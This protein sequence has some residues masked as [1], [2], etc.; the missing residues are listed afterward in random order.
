MVSRLLIAEVNGMVQDGLLTRH[1]NADTGRM[2]HTL[3]QDMLPRRDHGAHLLHME[4]MQ[5]LNQATIVALPIEQACITLPRE[6]SKAHPK[7]VAIVTKHELI[8][9][10]RRECSHLPCIQPIM[11]EVPVID[12]IL[13][14]LDFTI[15]TP[16]MK[17]DGLHLRGV[18]LHTEIHLDLSVRLPLQVSSKRC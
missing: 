9:D 4:D 15:T 13:S 7:S 3:F 2:E 11:K 17:W 5:G 12:K 6:R 16:L 10:G 8:E 1:M 18:T 14:G